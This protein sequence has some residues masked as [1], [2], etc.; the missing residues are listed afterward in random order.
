GSIS[1]SSGVTITSGTLNLDNSGTNSND[2]I[3]NDLSLGTSVLTFTGNA[4]ADTLEAFGKLAISGG[5][6]SITLSQSNGG[7]V[8][9]LA[10]SSFS[11][12]GTATAV[13][14]GTNLGQTATQVGRL[15]IN[16]ASGT[17]LA[18]VGSH[19]SATGT[20]SGTDKA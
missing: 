10:A 3:A 20:G 8:A 19:T 6:T 7:R 5:N 12:S 17:G 2:R 1:G 9:T 15:T 13:I 11:R 18:Q 14:L 16:G 4:S